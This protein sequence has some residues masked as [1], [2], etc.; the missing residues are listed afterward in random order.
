MGEH[1]TNRTAILA[2]MLPGFPVGVDYRQVRLQGGF[3]MRRNIVVAAPDH[4]RTTAEG[5]VEVLGADEQWHATPKEVRVV[6]EGAKLGY[7][8]LDFVVQLYG[9]RTE[10]RSVLAAS[11][12]PQAPMMA[13]PVAELARVPADEYLEAFEHRA[14]VRG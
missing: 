6:P 5:V 1:K 11:G 8:A 3:V 13:Q 4:I 10:E 7:D 14:K 12:Q 2:A 9:V